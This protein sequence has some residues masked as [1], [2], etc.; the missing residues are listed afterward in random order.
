MQSSSTLG[1]EGGT[2]VRMPIAAMPGTLQA[3]AAG[4]EREREGRKNNRGGL[5]AYYQS[6]NV[7][8][9]VWAG[10]VPMGS[11]VSRTV[12]DVPP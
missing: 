4:R 1:G 11:H 3:H 12:R 10:V 7:C 6:A 8:R 5:V 9:R 2:G